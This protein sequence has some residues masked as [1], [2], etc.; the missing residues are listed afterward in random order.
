[1]QQPR[2]LH[3]GVKQHTEWP[4]DLHSPEP[5]LHVARP[6]LVQSVAELCSDPP[7]R[8]ADP[9]GETLK[10]DP[11]TTL[12]GSGFRAQGMDTIAQGYVYCVSS[13]DFSGVRFGPD[14]ILSVIYMHIP[15]YQM[16]SCWYHHIHRPQDSPAH[17]RSGLHSLHPVNR[18][19][20]IIKVR[21]NRSTFTD[22]E[23]EEYRL[24]QPDCSDYDQLE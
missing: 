7:V 16:L 8:W 10:S 15:A 6:L 24:K 2:V 9:C 20:S 18:L 3:G 21:G 11:E 4:E 19:D 12:P 14:T 22:C 17:S 5:I 1:M 23:L 13:C